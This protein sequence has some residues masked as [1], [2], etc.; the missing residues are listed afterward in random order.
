MKTIV[1]IV[2]FSLAV[3][4][5]FSEVLFGPRAFLDANPYHFAPW[6]HYAREG[7]ADQKTYRTDALFTYFQR[8]V[9]LTRSIRSRRMP[10]W[11]PHILAGMPFFADPQSRTVYPI[12]LA[13]VAADPVDA[14]AYN[15]AIHL[16]IAMLG[17]YLFLRSI[18]VNLW[19]SLLG[20]FAFG[21][22]SFFYLRFGPPTI[23]SAAAWIPAARS[24]SRCSLQWAT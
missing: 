2:I 17:M 13:L 12:A 4:L 20:G 16:V 14:M 24:C 8:R 7:D 15:V 18:R 19:G 10:L 5:L 22:S 21:F 9:E 23:I 11:N 6:R 3:I 1:V